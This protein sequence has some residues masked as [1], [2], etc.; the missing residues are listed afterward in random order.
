MIDSSAP[1]VLLD[2]ARGG[3][4][5]AR[6]FVRPRRI[7][8][9]RTAGEVRALARF[10]ADARAE[11]LPVAGFLAYEAGYAFEPKLARLARDVPADAA[12]LAWFAAFE[13]VRTIPAA[14]VAALLPDPAGAWAGAPEPLITRAAYDR[15]IDEVKAYIAA[16]DIYQANLTFRA[17]VPVCGDPLAFY[18]RLRGSAAGWGGVVFTGEHWLL[19]A[20]PELFYTREGDRLTAR[21]MKGTA[22]RQ[23]DPAD[24]AAAARRLTEDAK[25]RAENLMIVDLLRND[26][27]RIS[28]AGSV[29]VPRLFDVETYPTV[30]QMTSTVTARVADPGLPPFGVVEA[31]F[32]CGSVT[33]APKI[34]A[35]EVIAKVEADA[36]GPYTG[37]IGGWTDAGESF[38]V[39]IR[40][41]VMRIGEE[42]AQLGLGSGVVA[43]STADAE[44]RECLAKGAFVTSKAARFDLLTTMRFDPADGIADLERHLARLKHSA[45]TLG[46]AFDR[47]GVRNELQAATFRLRVARRIRLRLSRTGAVATEV[48][49]LPPQVAGPVEVSIAPLPAAPADFRLRHKTSDRGFYDAARNAAGGFEVVFVDPAGFVTE[50]SF[51]NVFVDRGGL[52][53]TP[54]L[55]RGLLPGV[56][57]ARLI[58]EERAV[59]GDLRPVDLAGGFLIGNALRGLIP[60][61][62]VAGTDAPGL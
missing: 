8:V 54:P 42:H 50:G 43:D 37:S 52:L 28:A 23:A 26:F 16:G 9:A 15:A 32:P 39:A 56:L 4:A 7:A 62:L 49:P 48:R 53:V 36:R 20:S 61:R 3:A 27:S 18:A 34:R 10:V 40:T 29:A 35:M 47:H 21:P 13:E 14:D 38:N 45:E 60:A 51:T 41:L 1:F 58:E 31:L 17:H 12:P 55:A 57:R 22:A 30:H 5:T 46:F 19:S 33:G 44:W 25:E 59:E 24:D 2:D 6:L 11:R